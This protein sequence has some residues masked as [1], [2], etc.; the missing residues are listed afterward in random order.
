MRKIKPH[1]KQK[2]AFVRR[3]YRTLIDPRARIAGA[4]DLIKVC[5]EESHFSLELD[6]DFEAVKYAVL[7][8]LL[9][10]GYAL[11]RMR[12]WDDLQIAECKASKAGGGRKAAFMEKV[13]S[14]RERLRPENATLRNT[15]WAM[16]ALNEV[17]TEMAAR[18]AV[19]AVGDVE[20]FSEKGYDHDRYKC[21][22]L[23]PILADLMGK[24]WLPLR[25]QIFNKNRK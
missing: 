11:G 24:V 8:I 4:F 16:D 7:M 25:M 3:G 10:S 9:E 13:A 17:V 12:L 21:A 14:A 18:F 2:R 1:V 23:L 6:S 20:T 22:A 15:V 5:F 19:G